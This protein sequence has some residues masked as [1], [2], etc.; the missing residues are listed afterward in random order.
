MIVSLTFRTL[1]LKH[2][3][4]V[5]LVLLGGLVGTSSSA[6]SSPFGR[7]GSGYPGSDQ[8]QGLRLGPQVASLVGNVGRFCYVLVDCYSKKAE[9]QRYLLTTLY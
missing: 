6:R 9:L 7:C 3:R 5:V 1:I 2:V 8:H 4:A